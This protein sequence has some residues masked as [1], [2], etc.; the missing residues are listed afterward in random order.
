MALQYCS[1]T[2]GEVEPELS[3]APVWCMGVWKTTI[4]VGCGNGQ[5]EVSSISLS[6]LKK[7]E[8]VE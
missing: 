1:I 2:N 8:I 4:A 5:V 7:L 3:V 6:L